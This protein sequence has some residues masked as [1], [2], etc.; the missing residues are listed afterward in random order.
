M[1]RFFDKNTVAEAFNAKYPN[2]TISFSGYAGY[3]AN[4][5]FTA[6]GK[7]YTYSIYG[8]ADKLGI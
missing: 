2:G 4:V 6:T 7:T 8:L 1:T 3:N 5:Q